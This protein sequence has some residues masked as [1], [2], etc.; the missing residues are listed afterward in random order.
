[1]ALSRPKHGFESRW[2][3]HFT[4]H[5]REQWPD[6]SPSGELVVSIQLRRERQLA[7]DEPPEDLL[8][9]RQ[10]PA[11]QLP[12]I[13]DVRPQ[14][15]AHY[16]DIQLRRARRAVERRDLL[17]EIRAPRLCFWDTRLARILRCSA[18]DGH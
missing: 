2:G 14:L 10:L 6:R 18:F 4:Y 5:S 11:E 15:R 17:T 9:L 16:V 3:R 8:H 7:D 1:V 12:V 13:G